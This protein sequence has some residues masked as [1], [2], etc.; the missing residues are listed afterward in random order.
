MRKGV[1]EELRL[2]KKSMR[3][4]NKEEIWSLKKNTSTLMTKGARE[5]LII[6]KKSMRNGNKEELW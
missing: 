2:A 6:A 4:G 5:E 3:N 1:R